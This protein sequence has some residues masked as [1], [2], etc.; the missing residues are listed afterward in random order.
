MSL[1][2]DEAELE[3]IVNLVGMDA[4]SAPDR[5]KLE[6]ARSVREDYLHQDAFDD[7]D[8]YTSLPKQYLMLKAIMAY[9]EKAIGALENGASVNELIS[10][11]VRERIGRFKYSNEDGAKDEYSAILTQLQSEIDAACERGEE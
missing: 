7:I 10:L 3:E 1:L 5:I 11:P 4:L 2:Q 6:A 9:Y 8:T